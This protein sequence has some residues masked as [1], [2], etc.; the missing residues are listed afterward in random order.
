M[1]NVHVWI[2]RVAQWHTRHQFTTFSINWDIQLSQNLLFY[3]DMRLKSRPSW[4]TGTSDNPN[5]CRLITNLLRPNGASNIR[6]GIDAFLRPAQ[7]T[8]LLAAPDA[9]NEYE[10]KGKQWRDC[11]DRH[12]TVE[13]DT[14]IWNGSL[15]VHYIRKVLGQY[16][17]VL[18]CTRVVRTVD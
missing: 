7:L 13:T 5:R 3:K 14:V 16:Q 18:I 9:H 4:K 10:E 6:S 15:A 17:A 1:L 12:L 2:E 8:P 11:T